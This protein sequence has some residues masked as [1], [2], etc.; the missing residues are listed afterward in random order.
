M[1]LFGYFVC[2][3]F[4]RILLDI[5]IISFPPLYINFNPGFHQFIKLIVPGSD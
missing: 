4:N 1:L 2:Y 3:Q 5:N